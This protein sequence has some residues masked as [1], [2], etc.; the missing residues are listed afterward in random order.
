MSD[1][2]GAAPSRQRVVGAVQRDQT[3]ARLQQAAAE[4]FLEHGYSAA[5]VSRIASRAGVSVQTLYLA[6]G[7]K[8]ELL[9]AYLQAGLTGGTGGI[10]S[11][12][13][14]FAGRSPREVVDGLAAVVAR[15][16]ASAGSGWELYRDAAAGDPEIA[17]DWAELQSLR[18]LNIERILA[19]LPLESLRP[20]LSRES[21]RDS[22]WVIAGPESFDLLV[23]RSG[24]TLDEWESWMATTLAATLLR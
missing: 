15:I 9:R 16:G 13:D 6:W 17:A 1:D 2:K 5:T 23:R 22:A 12:A 10:T 14:G 24:Y 3:R 20:G 21:A 18:R 7:S 11:V 8:R 4:E 19:H